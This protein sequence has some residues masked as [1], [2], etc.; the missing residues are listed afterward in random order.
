MMKKFFTLAAIAAVV[1]SVS[2]TSCSK[3]AEDYV[4]EGMELDKQLVEAQKA[5]DEAKVKEIT[6]KIDALKKEID[7]KCKDE[8]FKKEF[9]EAVKKAL[10]ET[11]E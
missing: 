3:S 4:K 9:D 10:N 5:G 8:N 11:A 6:E 7:E 1:A 2:L